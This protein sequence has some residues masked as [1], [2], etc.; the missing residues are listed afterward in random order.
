MFTHL[1]THSEY[2]LLDGLCKITDL[3]AEAKKIGSDSIALTD[4][5]SLYGAVEFYK[6]SK[7]AGIKPIIGVEAYVAPQGRHSR[8]PGDTHPYHLVLLAKNK[9]GYHNLLKLVTLSH[10]EGFYYRPRVDRELLKQYGERIIAL[11]GC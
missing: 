6:E 9:Q 1:H 10:L 7:A 4:H 5:G 11:S 2:S 3:V 8:L